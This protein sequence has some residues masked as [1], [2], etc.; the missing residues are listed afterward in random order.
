[1]SSPSFSCNLD[2]TNQADIDI[3]LNHFHIIQGLG[4]TFRP[5]PYAYYGPVFYSQKHFETYEMYADLRKL[6]DK[7]PF[8]HVQPQVH[9][10]D[11]Y[12]KS[13]NDVLIIIVAHYPLHSNRRRQMAVNKGGDFF[14]PSLRAIADVWIAILE[15]NGV[16]HDAAKCMIYSSI[17]VFDV[18]P[19]SGD[20]KFARMG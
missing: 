18:L 13:L 20:S 19:I 6:R 16:H 5:D 14:E 15:Q 10:P 11:T 7:I 4:P 9:Y 3:V 17:L 12:A 2:P 1:M 8:D